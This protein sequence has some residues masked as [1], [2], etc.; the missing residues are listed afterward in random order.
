[1]DNNDL[2][3]IVTPS[4][5]LGLPG[6]TTEKLAEEM[7]LH[8]RSIARLVEAG[9]PCIEFV[10]PGRNRPIRRFDLDEV[11]KWMDAHRRGGSMSDPLPQP[12]PVPAKRG[13]PRRVPGAASP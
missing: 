12:T 5:R 11:R 2:K 10:T 9:L 7:S 13:R 3:V 1:M 8:P 4:E 6:L